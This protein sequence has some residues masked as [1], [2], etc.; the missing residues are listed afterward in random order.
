MKK[1][2]ITLMSL[3]LVLFVSSCSLEPTLAD[4]ESVEMPNTAAMRQMIDGSYLTMVNYRYMGRNMIVAGEV[5][6]DNVFANNSSGRFTRWSSMNILDTDGD[7]TDLM[8]YAYG[9]VAN[10]N[11]IIATD[12]DGIDGSDAD[13][14]QILGES[15]L[16]RAYAYFDL[17]RLFGQRYSEGSDLGISYIKAFKGPKNVVRQSVESNISDIKADIAQAISHFEQGT[18]SEW[19]N[20]KTNFNLPSAYALQSRVGIYFKDYAYAYEGSSQIVD[21]YPITPEANFVAYWSQQTPP[22]ASIMELY[23][24]TSTNNQSI[25]GIGN[26]YRESSYGDLQ[27]FDNI[28]ANAEFDAG[29][30]RASSDMID[31]EGDKL[32]NMGKYPSMGTLLGSDNIKVFRIEEIVLNHAEA[33]AN[34]AG[35]GDALAYLNSIPSNRGASTYGSASMDNIIKERRKELMFEGF[36]F[37]DLARTGRAIPNMNAPS[38]NHGEVAPGNFKFAFPIPSREIDSNRD[39]VQ[40]PG[41]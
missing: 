38:N 12:F 18:T 29:D 35:S 22:A 14:H 9:S 27:V 32:R 33:L 5:R 30:V 39:A 8:R 11:I 24:N 13:K 34:G 26:I 16:M 7:V 40:N 2:I 4:N 41:Y 37:F 15:Y 31:Y 1:N 20:S 17:V 10:P 28:I 21:D 36:R 3:A 6:A 25:N 19:A 23:Q